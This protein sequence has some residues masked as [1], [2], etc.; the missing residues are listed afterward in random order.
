[1]LHRLT[2]RRSYRYFVTSLINRQSVNRLICSSD[3]DNQRFL[4]PGT[5]VY[6]V[7]RKIH[8]SISPTKLKAEILGRNLPNLC[9]IRQTPLAKKGVEFYLRSPKCG[10]FCEQKN[11]S[12]NVGEIIPMCQ[13]HQHYMNSF[14]VPKSN[15]HLFCSCSLGINVLAQGTRHKS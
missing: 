10:E 14:F 13:F 15:K 1:M 5:P 8:H 2:C 6:G 12:A 11:S 4:R 9:A 3:D 7:R